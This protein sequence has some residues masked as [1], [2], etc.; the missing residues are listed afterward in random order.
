MELDQ[1]RKIPFTDRGLTAKYPRSVDVIVKRYGYQPLGSLQMVGLRVEDLEDGALDV[2]CG[3]GATLEQ[4]HEEFGLDNFH[5]TDILPFLDLSSFVETDRETQ[6]ALCKRAAKYPDK[7]KPGN[8]AKYIPYEDDEIPLVFNT[9]G[10][11]HYACS[12]EE[13]ATSIIEMARV[14][15]KRAVFT[16]HCPQSIDGKMLLGPSDNHFLFKMGNFLEDL[17]ETTGVVPYLLKNKR[18]EIYIVNLDTSGKRDD[19]Y[20]STKELIKRADRY[21]L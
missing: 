15:S 7:F 16:T 21:S 9:M 11:P 8:A 19:F 20:K 12:P 14:A 6:R 3:G 2:C 5:A 4:A 13:A 18:G 1:F 10:L 17:Q